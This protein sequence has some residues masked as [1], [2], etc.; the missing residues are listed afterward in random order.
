MSKDYTPEKIKK[1]RTFPVWNTVW[2]V[3]CI[4]L[5]IVFVIIA[6]VYD[7]QPQDVIKEYKITVEPREDGRLD[8][9]YSFLWQALD[10]SEPLTWVEIGMANPNYTVDESSLSDTISSYAKIKDEDYVALRLNFRKSYYGGDTLSF[11]FKITQGDM[12]CHKHMGYLYE[13]V[14]GWFNSTPV[15]HYEFRW[16]RSETCTHA[17]RANV[18]DGYYVWYGRLNPGEYQKL[19]LEYSAEAFEGAHSVAHYDFDDDGAYDAL[20]E[21]KI[22]IVIL[23]IFFDVVLLIIE[24]Y[25]ID[26]YVSYSRGRGFLVGYGHRVHVY[27]RTNPHYISARNKH[28]SSRGGGGGGRGCAC[29]CA[30]ACA[31][32]GRA[33]CSRKDG[34]SSKKTDSDK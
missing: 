3:V 13:Y 20:H 29:A 33:G 30:C 12:L 5:Q 28:A 9:E 6:A 8:I 25:I 23:M 7:P 32:G 18:E 24:I 34:F 26:S 31:G 11:S 14:P 2:L 4:I 16:K 19:Y 27:G 21:E 10:P 15:E 17:E 22:G 1:N